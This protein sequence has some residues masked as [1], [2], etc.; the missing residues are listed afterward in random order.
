MGRVDLLAHLQA[1]G[2]A[3]ID[4]RQQLVR[5]DSST[6]SGGLAALPDDPDQAGK[7]GRGIMYPFT[8]PTPGEWHSPWHAWML[9]PCR[10][11]VRKVLR[12]HRDTPGSRLD[13]VTTEMINLPDYGHN[14]RFSL[15]GQNAAIAAFVRDSWA[16]IAPDG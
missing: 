10:E 9:E 6:A 1:A 4:Q 14:A 12:Y 13:F 2:V 7:P 11:V 3:D 15:I 16:E 5:T 8:K